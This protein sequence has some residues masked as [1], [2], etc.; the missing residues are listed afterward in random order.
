MTFHDA[1]LVK[2]VSLPNYTQ[3]IGPPN[4]NPSIRARKP[5]P[6]SKFS[7]L[8]AEIAVLTWMVFTS[9]N[10]LRLGC[11]CVRVWYMI[12]YVP[13]ELCIAYWDTTTSNILDL[14]RISVDPESISEE[15]CFQESNQPS[16]RNTEIPGQF[17]VRKCIPPIPS[18]H[19]PLRPFNPLNGQCRMCRFLKN[20]FSLMSQKQKCPQKVAQFF[21]CKQMV[22]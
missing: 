15:V 8:Q 9:A 4:C 7:S 14:I 20:S 1:H 22:V 11:E 13:I 5:R 19:Y 2:H 21:F 18:W 17:E 12:V 10:F 6:T 3:T 16:Q